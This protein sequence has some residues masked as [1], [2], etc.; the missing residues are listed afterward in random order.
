MRYVQ[1]EDPDSRIRGVMLGELVG[2]AGC[3]DGWAGKRADRVSP[4][5]S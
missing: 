1:E 3:M 4:G 5:R 2:G